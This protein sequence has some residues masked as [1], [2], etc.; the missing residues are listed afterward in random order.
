MSSHRCPQ[1]TQLDARA[2]Q[3]DVRPAYSKVLILAAGAPAPL[4]FSHDISM[5]RSL[6][7]VL[8]V[9]YGTALEARDIFCY[10]GIHVRTDKVGPTM[11]ETT[12]S[13]FGI[14][15]RLPQFTGG[16]PPTLRAALTESLILGSARLSQN[17]KTLVDRC[18]QRLPGNLRDPAPSG[19]VERTKGRH[20]VLGKD[21]CGDCGL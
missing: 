12:A 3:C 11:L 13:T 17:A 1:T 8:I 20:R 19:F 18:C 14:F 15:H 21:V 6:S 4:H 9:C 16:A 5:T 10:L 2:R 7:A